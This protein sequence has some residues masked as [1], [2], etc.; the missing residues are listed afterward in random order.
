VG[1]LLAAPDEAVPCA[2]LYSRFS[3]GQRKDLPMAE[4]PDP[5][6]GASREVT[7]GVGL[8]QWSPDADEAEARNRYYAQLREYRQAI[9]DPAIP[10]SERAEAQRSYDDLAAFLK[11]HYHPA[12]DPGWAVTKLVHRSLRR[13]CDHLREPLPGERAPNPV[14]AA[15][16]EYIGKHILVPSRRYTRAKPG[17]NVRVARG[18]LAGRLIF[19]CP[20]GD[21]WSVQL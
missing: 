10:E 19:E 2:K 17:A 11:E 6:T 15:L 12:P 5:E 8:A 7:D 1:W 20:P 18:E 4:L 3:A 13:L 16:G 14:V 21:R 9:D